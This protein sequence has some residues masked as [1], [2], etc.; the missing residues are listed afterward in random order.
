METRI[1]GDEYNITWWENRGP[2]DH[3]ALIS[4]KTCAGFI[5]K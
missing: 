4:K 5:L 2:E 1:I 3:S